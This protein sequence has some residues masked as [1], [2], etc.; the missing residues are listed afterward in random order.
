VPAGFLEA[1]VRYQGRDACVYQANESGL[2]FK[3]FQII[4]LNNIVGLISV[5]FL[6][7]FVAFVNFF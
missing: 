1:E 3:H 6:K 4:A 2:F 5:R 7:V